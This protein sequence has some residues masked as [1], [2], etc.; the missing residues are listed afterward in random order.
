MLKLQY[1]TD[2]KPQ[3]YQYKAKMVETPLQT[4]KARANM[5][6]VSF[7]PDLTAIKRENAII[8]SNTINT[9]WQSL[10]KRST[11]KRTGQ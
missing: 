11:A 10:M 5:H 7:V 9:E 1:K 8:H 6:E 2:W 3:I 4:V